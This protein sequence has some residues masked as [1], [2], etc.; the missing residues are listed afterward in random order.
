MLAMMQEFPESLVIFKHVGS[1]NPEDLKQNVKTLGYRLTAVEMSESVQ[2]VSTQV[3]RSSRNF[4]L[5]YK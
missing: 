3:I 4:R 1:G 5:V 2:Y